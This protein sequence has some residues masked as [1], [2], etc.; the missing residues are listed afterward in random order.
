MR[1]QVSYQA[2]LAVGSRRLKF[3]SSI[4]PITI[5]PGMKVR[6][7]QPRLS[8]FNRGAA[9]AIT[10][11]AAQ[12]NNSGVAESSPLVYGQSTRRFK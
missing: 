12:I 6:Q 11:P 4:I 7:R 3:T 8:W 5:S 10:A 1:Q 2:S 9:A